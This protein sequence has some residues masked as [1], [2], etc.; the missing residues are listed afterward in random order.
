MTI[1]RSFFT[2]F[3]SFLDDFYFHAP[4]Q[5]SDVGNG[6]LSTFSPDLGD[7]DAGFLETFRY[8]PCPQQ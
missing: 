2:L 5:F 7:V 3:S 1:G 8:L 6:A 4:V